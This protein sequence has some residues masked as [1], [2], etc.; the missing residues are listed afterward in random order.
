VSKARLQR[1]VAVVLRLEPGEGLR[2]GLMLLYSVAV[3]GGVVITGQ[4]VSRS[5][6]LSALP[7]TDIPYKFILPPL[8]LMVATGIYARVASRCRRDRLIMATCA[9]MVVAVAG[10]RLLLSSGLRQEFG[11]LCALFVVFDVIG[12]LA[13]IQFWTF[14]GDLFNAREARRLFGLISAGSA[15][16]NVAF[17]LVLSSTADLVRPENLTFA[18]M[19]SLV[20][21]G[22]CA[23]ILG[24]RHRRSLAEVASEAL[25]VSGDEGK[26][27]LL[28]AFTEIYRVPL[29]L[30]MGGIVILTAVVS[31]I[32]DYQLDL[33][34]QS[35]FGHSGQAMVAFLGQFRCGAGLAAGVLQLFLAGRLMERFGV[36]T[37]LLLLPLSVAMGS[38]ALLLTGGVLWAAAI[39]RACDVVLKYSVNDAALNLLYLPVGA[40]LR[41]RAKA[42]LDGMVR[43]PVVSLLGVAFLVA[44]T[45]FSLVQ[46]SIPVLA[47][48][49]VWVLLVRRASRQY[50]LA[51]GESIQY[52]RLDLDRATVD[53]TDESSLRVIRA[54]LEADDDLRVVH[55]LSLLQ[56]I[57]AVDWTPQVAGL[58]RHA[59]AGVRA[60]A[61]EHLGQDGDPGHTDLVRQALSDHDEEVRSA[62]VLALCALEGHLAIPTISP[63]LEDASV[64]VRG[65]SVMGL[66]RH[67]GL[68]GVLR[69]GEHLRAMLSGASPAERIEGLRALATL[70]MPT[71]YHPLV[72]LLGDADL[73]V[74]LAAIRAAGR[75]GSAE[76]IPQLVSALASPG[77]RAAAADA[78]AQSLDGDISPLVALL[79]DPLQGVRAR[80][81]LILIL[82][83]VSGLASMQY[84]IGQLDSPEDELRGA[85]YTALLSL[86]ADGG[87]DL[88]IGDDGWRAAIDVELGRARQFHLRRR[89]LQAEGA[90]MLL[91]D[92][93]AARLGAAG[94]RLLSLLDLLYP[95]ISARRVRESLSAADPRRRASAIELLDNVLDRGLRH[96][97]LPLLTAAQGRPMASTGPLQNGDEAPAETHLLSLCRDPDPWVR[98]CALFDVGIRGLADL[99]P[100]LEENLRAA[101]AIVR[102][103]ALWACA[104][105]TPARRLRE[106]LEGLIA[107]PG[108]AAA[109]P[110]SAAAHERMRGGDA[111]MALS[112][113]EKV[114][115]LKSVPM[116]GHIAGEEIVDIVPILREV[117]IPE[118]D[119]FIRKG[120]EGDC[121]YILVEGE[122]GVTARSGRDEVMRSREVIGELAALTEQPRTA[123]CVAL[124]DLVVL[125]IDKRD[126]WELMDRQP[127]LTIEIMKVLVDRYVSSREI[128]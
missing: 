100:H 25:P 5:L 63:L 69:G 54:A 52:R 107:T 64:R 128:D 116:F 110:Y 8:A 91:D 33:A 48:V 21:C 73:Q 89:A 41:A 27:G 111:T 24:H 67:A 83:R 78:I 28:S 119:T 104:Q 87:P 39:P 71:F 55:A 58:A 102:E 3:V 59:H 88:P 92:A 53:L 108:Y 57:S 96:D 97:L 15:V 101:D 19:A 17:G 36:A 26:D 47:L 51:L 9:I 74:Q 65:A 82:G 43:P 45:T 81:Q 70:Q 61:I 20:V 113:L 13:I 11:T 37:V 23:G 50:V 66:I 1:A 60:L 14:A 103:T 99:T 10:F 95:E 80:G 125:R 109:N 124:T 12:D 86:R 79:S 105:V 18:M 49:A 94:L 4:L 77:T 29:L 16:S 35:R 115:F 98:A 40:R 56:G 7:A 85:A 122:V 38:G 126:L 44:G 32:A 31:N 72:E 42:I 114:F 112:T 34:L 68:D 123:D 90:G 6:F 121:L 118:G 84:L 2:V 30:T 62:A 106:Q 117:Q 127:R 46:W 120:D 76:F 93:L 75:I 22:I